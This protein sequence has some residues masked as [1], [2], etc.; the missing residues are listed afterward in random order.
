[1]FFSSELVS[2]VFLGGRRAKPLVLDNGKVIKA[3]NALSAET[4]HGVRPVVVEEIQV[5][6]VHVAVRGIHVTRA[7]NQEGRLVVVSDGEVQSLRL[8][9]CDS[10]K[11]SSCSECV[12]LQ[13][14]YCA[15]DKVQG[16]CRSF[17]NGKW[18]EENLFYQS[19]ANGQHT[20]CPLPKLGKDAGSV[21]G[22]SS[23]QPKYNQD[24]LPSLPGG[25]VI[26]IMQD[27]EFEPN[28]GK[29]RSG[30]GWNGTHKWVVVGDPA[31]TAA[32]TLPPQYS[33]ETLVMAVVAGALSALVIGF[34]AG[35]FCG[36]K[37]HKDDDD[38]LPYP[39]TEYE[40]FE[41]RQNMNR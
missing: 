31:V 32:D 14:P 28:S 2:L 6:P 7:E 10:N 18:G 11:I 5:F 24:Q 40:Y 13:D 30:W 1:M 35:Y 16:K 22:L 38:N 41:Q 8:H 20:A 9:R 29:F 21:G 27:R 36:R 25:Q 12:A 17:G 26:N 39:D 34:I 3:V 33:V 4:R 15:W 37:C 23:T 19:V